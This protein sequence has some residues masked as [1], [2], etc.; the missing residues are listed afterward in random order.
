MIRRVSWIA[1]I[2]ICV[3]FARTA[4]IET[5]ITAFIPTQE[6]PHRI[7]QA[8]AEGPTSRLMIFIVES[9]TL[10][11][12]FTDAQILEKELSASK[13]FAWVQSGLSNASQTDLFSR[14]FDKR[15]NFAGYTEKELSHL[16][17]DQGLKERIA[18]LKR[19]LI[20]PESPV[21]RTFAER[22]PLMLWWRHIGS[23]RKMKSPFSLNNNRFVTQKGDAAVLFAETI[24]S[25]FAHATQKDLLNKVQNILSDAQIDGSKISYTGL[26]RFAAA[27]ETTM[28]QDITR[29]SVISIVLL[30]ILLWA[31][32]GSLR[33]LFLGIFSI[34]TGIFAG[35][36][37][38]AV[39]W[40][41]IHALTLAF[42]ATLIGIAVDYPIHMFNHLLLRDPSKSTHEM[43]KHILPAL[44]L[45]AVTTIAGLALLGWTSFPGIRQIAV[46]STV[47]ITVAC[48]ATLTWVFKEIPHGLSA[49]K[50]QKR[51]VAMIENFH[52]S[53]SHAWFWICSATGVLMLV[54]ISKLHWNDNLQDLNIVPQDLRRI[55]QEIHARVNIPSNANVIVATGHT[56]NE[57]LAANMSVKNTN[58]LFWDAQAQ[59]QSF[60]RLHHADLKHRLPPLLKQA[61]FDPIAFAPFFDD[62]N[63]S[64]FSPL[65]MDDLTTT[66]LGPW[67]A[68]SRIQLKDRIGILSHAEGL[69][70][71]EFDELRK[72]PDIWLLNPSA[73][74]SAATRK[75]RTE[76]L[77]LVGIGLVVIFVMLVL[78][79]KNMRTATLGIMPGLLAV[80]ITASILTLLGI[81]LNML[82]A[83]TSILVLSMGVDYGVFL[84]DAG[85]NHHEHAVTLFG[86]VIACLSTVCSFGLLAL[87]RAPALAS[88]GQMAGLGVLLSFVLSLVLIK[89]KKEN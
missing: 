62:L 10:E 41:E 26:N 52:R 29:I 58:H 78:R 77:Q 64:V 16:L 85:Q 6:D 12:A 89:P 54:S 13:H 21:I 9:S 65:R 87:S 56:E 31:S 39:I 44:T 1:F 14:T 43:R 17:S 36:A 51:A 38:C 75:F 50:V 69:T 79:Y 76:I 42:G 49:S 55:D 33:L 73:V 47:G 86:I 19:S 18:E 74:M 67:L 8:L 23:S 24:A 88:I 53:P 28:R 83:M 46:F 2:V 84:L 60:H 25:P 71:E 34:A 7:L 30:A 68:G 20:S 32:F 61:G 63:R 82:H 72:Q 35:Y 66:S 37:A 57:A 15:F 81:E 22:D 3:F 45:G 11:K 27:A 40:Q 4:S 80:A 5:A 59:E 70:P 48:L